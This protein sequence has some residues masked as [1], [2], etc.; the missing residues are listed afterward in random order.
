MRGV[1]HNVDES[2]GAGLDGSADFDTSTYPV[3]VSFVVNGVRNSR[4]S[5]SLLPFQYCHHRFAWS[6]REKLAQCIF[7]APRH[8]SFFNLSS[9]WRSVFPCFVCT[10]RLFPFHGPFGFFLS[11]FCARTPVEDHA[12]RDFWAEKQFG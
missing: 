1:E 11:P 10:L 6:E 12:T 8:L 7:L 4:P 3:F 9:S 5:T 2:R